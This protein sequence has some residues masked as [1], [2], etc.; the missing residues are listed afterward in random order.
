L[1][2]NYTNQQIQLA[3]LKTLTAGQRAQEFP[4]VVADTLLNGLLS[5]LSAT[6]EKLA[7]LKQDYGS[8]H[9]DVLRTKALIDEI[10]GQ[11]RDRETGILASLESQLN[12]RKAEIAKL[13]D[14]LGTASSI[15]GNSLSAGQPSSD[16]EEVQEI[17]RIQQMIQNSPDLINAPDSN[18][19]TPLGNVA[20]HGWLKAAAFLL[21]HGAEVNATT[22]GGTA[23]FEATQA[24]NRTMVDFLLAHGAN[25]NGVNNNN[26]RLPLQIA[27]QHGFEAVTEVLLDHK[28]GVNLR[29]SQ[30]NTPLFPAAQLGHTNIVQMLLAAGAGVDVENDEGRTPLSYAAES[31]LPEMVKMLLAAK[32]DPNAGK[33]DAPLL[34]AINNNEIGSAELLLQAGAKPN[35]IGNYDLRS[36]AGRR[37][38]SGGGFGGGR[39]GGPVGGFG[40]GRAGGLAGGFGGLPRSVTPFWLAISGNQLPMVQLLLKY[41]AD[42]NDSQTDGR[43]L[44]FNALSN[45]NILEALLDAGAKID[46]MGACPNVMVGGSA[47]NWTPLGAAAQQNDAAAV[48]ILLNHGANPNLRDSIGKFTPLHWAAN[49][50]ADRKVFELLLAYKAD[51]NVRDINGQA[52]LDLLKEKAEP[53]NLATDAPEKTKAGELADWLRQQGTLPEKP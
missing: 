37:G 43:S 40:G 6:E 25:A 24:G 35:A 16:I 23:L 27:V 11:I 31:G 15:S 14:A 34:C 22:R 1:E 5:Q 21:D 50:V 32:A 41:K 19:H 51:R 28:A 17:A 47:V 33:L 20:A 42:P 46:A 53:G 7:V 48:E 4:S 38:R 10:N 3:R 30:G 49:G 39:V 36:Q 18:G 45:T 2:A 26:N 12:G 8:N 44:L 29:D 9:P 13:Q 52:P